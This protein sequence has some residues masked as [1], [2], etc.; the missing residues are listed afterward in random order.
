MASS[1]PVRK[2]AR[3]LL[4]DA[5]DRILLQFFSRDGGSTGVWI[6]PGGAVEEG[7][8]HEEAALR[9]LKE[10]AG[11]SGVALGPCVWQRSFV[12]GWNDIQFEQQELFFVCRVESHDVSTF[13]IEDE[14][15]RRVT[16]EQRWWSIEEI[17]AATD[18]RF[19][20]TALGDLLGQI[21]SGEYPSEPLIVE[22]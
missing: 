13:V 18:H 7:E 17:V 15:E 12:I 6:T 10:E 20:P 1:V 4:I 11:L 19:G 22:R 9:E 2:A 8:T 3:V 21:L 14:E 5:L 16:T